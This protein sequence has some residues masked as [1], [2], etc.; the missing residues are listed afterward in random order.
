MN[1][2]IFVFV[3]VLAALG[4]G[5][6]VIKIPNPHP[7]ETKGNSTTPLTSGVSPE[8]PLLILNGDEKVEDYVE[9][10]HAVEKSGVYTFTVKRKVPKQIQLAIYT[11]HTQYIRLISDAPISVSHRN[12]F[13]PE[14]QIGILPYLVN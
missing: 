11:P 8:E 9:I 6:G 5:S 2:K 12:S 10:S 4:L 7:L 3:F 13:Q 1:K 14:P